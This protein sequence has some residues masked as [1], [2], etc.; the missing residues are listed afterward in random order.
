MTP[1]APIAINRKALTI[2]R[3]ALIIINRRVGNAEK[4]GGGH[5][6]PFDLGSDMFEALSPQ[7]RPSTEM[8]VQLGH[9]DYPRLSPGQDVFRPTCDRR[10]GETV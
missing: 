10:Q 9:R 6:T 1:F 8:T 7:K 2:M 5:L 4:R 3:P